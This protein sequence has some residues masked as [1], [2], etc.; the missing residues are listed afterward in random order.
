MLPEIMARKV[1]PGH[2]SATVLPRNWR[3][4]TRPLAV[5]VGQARKIVVRLLT[6]GVS[7]HSP[8]GGT[9]WVVETAAIELELKIKVDFKPEVGYV[10]TLPQTLIRG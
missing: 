6:T 3:T 2:A 4:G 5:R 10:V 8:S 7:G 1:F 9:L